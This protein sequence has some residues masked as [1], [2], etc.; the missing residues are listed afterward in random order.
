MNWQGET[1]IV[2]IKWIDLQIFQS[3]QDSLWCIN[4]GTEVESILLFMVFT[5]Y[6][7]MPFFFFQIKLF[8]C[9]TVFRESKQNRRK[10]ETLFRNHCS[11]TIRAL[12]S[13]QMSHSIRPTRTSISVIN[14]AKSLIAKVNMWGHN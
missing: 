2:K 7:F 3:V 10:Q 14:S 8:T 1:Q 6:C 5:S 13:S 11:V 12:Y 4:F 9:F